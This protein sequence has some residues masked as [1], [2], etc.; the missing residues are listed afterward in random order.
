MCD[1]VAAAA[2]STAGSPAVGAERGAEVLDDAV[3]AMVANRLVDPCSKRR[4]AEWVERDVVMPDGV[5]SRRRCDQYYRALDVVADTK[6]ATETQLYAALCD[7]T[8]LDLRL[9]CYDLTSTYFEG[10]PRPSARFPSKA[11]GYSRDHRSDRPQVVIGLLCTSDGIPIAHHVFAGNTADVSTLPGVL[12]DLPTRFG[13]GRICVVADRGLISADNVEVV[14]GHGFDHVLA[15]RLHRD[16]DLR[17]SPQRRRRRR[18]D[19]GAGARPQLRRLRRHRRDGRRC[20]GGAP[21]RTPRTAT[22]CAPP[23]S[24]PA[25]KPSCSPSSGG[26]VTVS[27]STPA[28]SAAPRNASSDPPASP[29]CSTSRSP[30]AAS[31]TTTTTPPSPTKTLLAGRYVLTTSLTAAEASTAQVVTAYRQLH[32]SSTASGSSRTSCTCARS[33]TGPNNASAVTSPSASTP[34]SSKPSSP[35]TSHAAD[36]RDPDLPD[37]HLTA[38]GRCASSPDPRRHP[39][40]RRPH[41]QRRHPPHPAA[42]P[43]PRAPSTS[44]PAPGTG[45]TSPDPGPTPPARCSGNTFRRAPNYQALRETPAELGSE[46]ER[47]Q[48]YRQR[49]AADL[50]DPRALRRDLRTERRRTAGLHQENDRLRAQLGAVEQRAAAAEESA[51][52]AGDRLAGF[53]E[54]ADRDRGQLLKALATLARLEAELEQ[55]R[56]RALRQASAPD[57]PPVRGT[58]I[59]APPL[60]VPVRA[61]DGPRCFAPGCTSPVTCRVQG[62]LASSVRPARP[63][64]TQGASR[65][66]GGWFAGTSEWSGVWSS[67]RCRPFPRL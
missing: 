23:S 49:L 13:V 33:G 41:H 50:E 21:A 14:D 53:R 17:R 36:V 6:E 26:S 45:P 37:Q 31:S 30:R 39:R 66:D 27:S 18:R 4:L 46:A 12:D 61:E 43:H 28:R 16:P 7:L 42:S 1:D 29:G 62:P 64:P 59:P 2:A 25:P 58:V 24:S 3:F 67:E 54:H 60:P 35:T 51:R 57:G 11:F 44:T 47:K 56:R 32:Q 9:V 8:N 19:V 10:S 65:I 40:R 15:T 52:L 22:R 63:T 5:Q 48:A 34:P 20:R 55:L 38:P